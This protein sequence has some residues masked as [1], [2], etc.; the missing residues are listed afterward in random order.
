[1]VPSHCSQ[2]LPTLRHLRH[3]RHLRPR[4]D[5]A[6]H[7]CSTWK[8]SEAATSCMFGK[9][10]G[11]ADQKETHVAEPEA[12]KDLRRGQTSRHE[13]LAN[14]SKK[15]GSGGLRSTEAPADSISRRVTNRALANGCRSKIGTQNGTLVDGIKTKSWLCFHPCPNGTPCSL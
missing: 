7:S 4:P 9:G 5:P 10:T 3:L 8:H 1:M 15:S 14:S 2:V 11:V 13:H 6:H 12:K